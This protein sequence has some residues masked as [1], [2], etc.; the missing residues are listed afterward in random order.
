MPVSYTHLYE[1]GALGDF[2]GGEVSAS[3]SYMVGSLSNWSPF[4][5]GALAPQMDGIKIQTS[6]SK[7]YY[8]L[9]KTW[10]AGNSSYYPTVKSTEDD[11]AGYPGKA[12][13][14]LAIQVFR[15]DGTKLTSGVIVMYRAFA[16]GEWLPWV[17][18]A[19]P[20]WMRNA[21]NKYSLGAV[22]YTHLS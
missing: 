10:N 12:I 3:L 20:E 18:N 11:Y 15:N 19:D 4:S 1:E 13:Q 9:Y 22:S 21:Q 7:D 2:T 16:E 8:L 5:K 14:R 17:S 6:A